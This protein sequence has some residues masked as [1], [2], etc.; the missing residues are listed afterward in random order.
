VVEVVAPVKHGVVVGEHPAAVP[1]GGGAPGL[2]AG[3]PELLLHGG[4][5]EG[6]PRP[7]HRVE[8]PRPDAV[9]DHVEGAPLGARA[10]DGVART[11]R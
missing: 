3:E 5:E 1:L 7:T 6:E 8:Q 10:A 11:G 2:V 4:A 9:A